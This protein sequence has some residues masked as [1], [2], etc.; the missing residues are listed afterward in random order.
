VFAVAQN[1]TGP[2]LG[3]QKFL[4]RCARCHG[5][6]G[7]GISAVVTIAGPS[8]QAEHDPGQVMKALEVGPSHMP[9]FQY[10]LTVGQMNAV[11]DY[12]SQSIAVIPL[13][14]GN[15]SEG[16]ELF[17]IHCAS[18][19][20]T[21]VRGG[22]LAFA[23]ENAPRLTGKSAA[24]IA[25]AIRWGPGAMPAFP[26]SIVNDKQLSSIVEYIRYVQRPPSPGG[27]PIKWYGPTTEG[28]V[29]WT[30]VIGLIF[31]AMWIEKGGSG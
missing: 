26:A 9:Q 31:I 11:S 14:P 2:N 15:L 20:R 16:G 8:L 22:A 21:A 3:R 10:V 29:A 27:N 5:V 6:I 30:V 18:C 1:P 17:R 4:D 12:V 24:L 25:G 7:E 23:G 28:Y 19:H 13:G